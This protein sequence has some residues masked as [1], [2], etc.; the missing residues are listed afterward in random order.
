MSVTDPQSVVG[1]RVVGPDGDNIGKV[2][3][4]YLIPIALRAADPS[5]PRGRAVTLASRDGDDDGFSM[6][7]GQ[8]PSSPWL[9]L[10]PAPRR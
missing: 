1:S 2:E 4:L 8:G 10:N 6:G 9:E 7:G 5:H 3:E